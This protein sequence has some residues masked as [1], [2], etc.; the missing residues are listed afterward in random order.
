MRVALSDFVANTG[1]MTAVGSIFLFVTALMLISNID[2][3]LN[4]I[5]QRL[6]K[7]P[8]VVHFSSSVHSE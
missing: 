4:Y 5:W 7:A 8:F 3:N 6:F 2:K 1:K